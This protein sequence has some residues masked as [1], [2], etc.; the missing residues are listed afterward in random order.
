VIVYPMAFSS[1]QASFAIVNRGR[2]DEVIRINIKDFKFGSRY[3]TYTLTGEDNVDFSRKVWVNGTGSSLVAGG[4]LNYA[5]I[6]AFSSTIGDE[7]KI[8]LPPLSSTF[9]LVEPGDKELAINEDIYGIGDHSSASDV[10][11]YPNPATTKIN[12]GNIPEGTTDLKIADCA[13]KVLI[14]QAIENFNASGIEM[15]TNLL[16]GLYIVSFSGAEPRITKKLIIK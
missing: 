16:P 6:P 14:E 3:Y 1:G 15:S 9:V 8:K 5:E 11:I 2:N 12:I 4:P 10:I 13:G 7:I